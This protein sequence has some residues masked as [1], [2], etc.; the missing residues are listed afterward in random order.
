ML[1]KHIAIVCDLS[2]NYCNYPDSISAYWYLLNIAQYY[3]PLVKFLNIARLHIYNSCSHKL[4]K[5]GHLG[6]IDI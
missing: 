2:L 3:A 6:I 1:T 5:Y 4:S